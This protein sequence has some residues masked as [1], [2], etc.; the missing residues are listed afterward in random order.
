MNQPTIDHPTDRHN[1]AIVHLPQVS[2]AFSYDTCIAYRDRGP[3]VV[4]HN[5]WGPTTGKHMNHLDNGDK[6]DRVPSDQFEDQVRDLLTTRLP[7]G[8]YV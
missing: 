6:T 4:R 1:F 3:W 5:G 8:E 2:L 7:T